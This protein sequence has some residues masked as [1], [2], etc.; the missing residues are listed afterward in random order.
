[1]VFHVRDVP[2]A[3]E[4]VS[5]GNECGEVPMARRE[6]LGLLQGVEM[7]KEHEHEWMPTWVG[8][9]DGPPPRFVMRS[10]CDVDDCD[11][12]AYEV[13]EASEV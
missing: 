4:V 6:V 10:I 11:E 1:M 12:I 13:S 5:E 3:Q 2:P 9:M 7:T 8:F